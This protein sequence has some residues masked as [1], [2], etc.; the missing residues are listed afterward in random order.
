[1][2]ITA[3][4][5]THDHQDLTLDTLDSIKHYMT[6]DVLVVINES[7]W[8][9]F[10][11]SQIPAHVLKAFPHNVGRAPYRNAMLGLSMAA[12]KW[13]DS[14]WYCH[15]EYDCL[16]GS[17]FFKKDLE[18][19]D[20]ENVWVIGNDYRDK[21][22]VRFP[23]VELMLKTQFDEIVYLLGA[24]LFYNSKFIK[25][26]LEE[27]F[28]NKFLFYTN[29][30]RGFFFPGYF[31]EGAWDIT[32]HMM[33]T[34]AK[35]WGGEVKQFAKW[36]QKYGWMGAQWRKYPVRWQPEL[37]NIEDEYLQASL[38][39]PLKTYDHPIREFHRQKRNFRKFKNAT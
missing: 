32:E 29:E 15:L 26:C 1:M 2:K 8:D 18:F 6:D 35:H 5:H 37:F 16:I 7:G 4:L 36:S 12:Q 27:D 3:I 11:H 13:P 23:L 28:F 14:D 31:G 9:K 39:H 10:D 21:Q 17:S 20:K 30:F 24:I 25:R 33:P 34:L 38:M 19:A 22:T